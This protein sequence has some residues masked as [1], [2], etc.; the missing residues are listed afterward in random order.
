MKDWIIMTNDKD[1]CLNLVC[2]SL[3]FFPL[4]Y[5]DTKDNFLVE[6]CNGGRN[7]DYNIMMV[8]STEGLVSFLAILELIVI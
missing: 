5:F 4:S 7:E 3:D 8:D 6:F 2:S 1:D